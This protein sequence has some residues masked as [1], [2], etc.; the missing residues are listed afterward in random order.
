MNFNEMSIGLWR[1]LVRLF[2]AFR[3]DPSSRPRQWPT[4]EE[5]MA[6]PWF[7]GVGRDQIVM[8]DS[9]QGARRAYEEL[10]RLAVVGFDTESKPTF[11]KGEKSRGPHVAQFSTPERSYVFTLH[12]PENR[13]VVGALMG[14]ASL[15]KVGFGLA[16]DVK[17]VRSKLGVIPKSVLDLET[18]CAQRGYGRGVGVKV[19]VAMVF[20]RRFRKSKKI[21]TSNWMNRQLTDQQVLYAANDAHAAMLV[22]EAIGEKGK[23]KT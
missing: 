5:M 4:R 20:K 1:W 2:P 21:G 8:I 16:D 14:L 13:R 18:L 3:D 17:R 10:S 6:L 19:A 11:N 7:D 23:K 12:Q 22:F 9:D 15:K